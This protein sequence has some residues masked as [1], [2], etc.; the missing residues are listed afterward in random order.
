[1]DQCTLSAPLE[2]VA[3]TLA[4]GNNSDSSS[5]SGSGS[6]YWLWS[7]AMALA[8]V[9]AHLFLHCRSLLTDSQLCNL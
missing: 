5:S 9:L 3:L 4:P 6:G 1:M 8:L 2:H 7:L